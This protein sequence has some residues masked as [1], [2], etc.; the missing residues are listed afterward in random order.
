LQGSHVVQFQPPDLKYISRTAHKRLEQWLIKKGW[1]LV[2]RSGTVGRVA[3]VPS[4]WDGWAAS[5][6]ILRI[7]P[8][9]NDVC[10]AGYLYSY[11]SS[12]LG[13]AQ[14]TAQ[15][16]GAVVD[17]L[18]ERQLK[19]VLVPVAK[20]PKQQRNINEINQ[21]ALEAISKKQEAVELVTQAV[22]G[23]STLIPSELEAVKKP[24]SITPERV[25]QTG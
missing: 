3:I 1:I 25:Q 19:G 23:I 18:T 13:Q 9:E 22:D 2:T 14:L 4:Q 21:L 24:A 8:N 17:E 6:H 10:P 7:I 11:L 5:E 16:Y 20:T 12:S 15:I